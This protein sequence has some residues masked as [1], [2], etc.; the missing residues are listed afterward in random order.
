MRHLTFVAAL[1]LSGCVST[2]APPSP[3]RT[4]YVGAQ[5]FDGESFQQRDLV[6]ESGRIIDAP[7]ATAANR[8]D[9]SGSYIVPPFCEA[10]NHNLGLDDAVDETIARY[11]R[12]GIF[13]VGTLSN[14]PAISDPLRGAYNT[15]QS[16][17]TIFA[18]GGLT[19][20]G[21]HPV[22]L[23]EFLLDQGVY[24]G[25]TRET[26]ADH[27][28][29]IIDNEADL[30]RRW[31]IIMGF[32]PDMIK[33]LLLYS[34]EYERRRDDPAFFGQKGLNPA[35]V[36]LIVERAHAAGL[37]AYAHIE[38]GHDFHV[39]VEAGVDVIAHLPGYS[40]PTRID[41]ADARRAAE[42]GVRLIT[43][44]VIAENPRRRRSAEHSAAVRAA[45]IE[46][47]RTLRDAGVTLAV[48]SDEYDQTS[49]YEIANLRALNVFSNAEL[50]R[51][52]SSDCS[53][54]L[55]PQRRLGALDAGYEASFLVLA[56]N[57][58]ENFDA[59]A[60]IRMTVKEGQILMIGSA[61]R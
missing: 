50:L 7:A 9:V 10:H 49:S 17:D 46:N 54:T 14:L 24:P 30:E 40:A 42:R 41:P 59:T 3:D 51:M 57:P 33:I 36:P 44:T 29:F 38:T 28:Y 39:A 26:L 43:T 58:L 18:N 4:A 12:E 53:T 47:L 56:G 34:E 1:A 13:Y 11:L 8:V 2:A 60:S 52:W 16:V 21:G 45:Q 20:T 22:R 27:A 35:L 31:P 15:P 55:F 19:G 37:R 48:G 32:R 61:G 25:F 6:V 23:R 5:V